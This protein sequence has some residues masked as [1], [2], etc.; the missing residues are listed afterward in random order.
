M[1]LEST[2]TWGSNASLVLSVDRINIT[3]AAE[4]KGGGGGAPADA[5]SG[6]VRQRFPETVYWNA[7]VTTDANGEAT[8]SAQLADNLT[9]WRMRAKAVTKDTLVG[10]GQ[11][12]ILST[13]DLLVRPVTPR[14]FVVGDKLN[15]AAVVH[16]NTPAALDVQV[17][18]Q[19]TGIQ[20]DGDARQTVTIPAGDKA[21]VEWPATV[22]D[23]AQADLTFA[24]AGGGLSDAS[25][26][27]A[28]LPPETLK[29]L[30]LEPVVRVELD[31]DQAE[32]YFNC[33]LAHPGSDYRRAG[34][35][36]RDCRAAQAS[37]YDAG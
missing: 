5:E 33:G 12:D 16:N 28:G 23:A 1:P 22:L 13:K 2:A 37:R 17:T 35:R 21:R 30:L 36:D 26:P 34:G 32:F 9:T 3:F 8:V 18:L 29:A 24:A 25:K 27:P 10:E 11:V 4:G 6:F 31:P 14:F 15:L 7:T 20:L 19:G